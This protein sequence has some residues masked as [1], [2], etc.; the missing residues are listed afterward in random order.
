MPIAGWNSSSAS[1]KPKEALKSMLRVDEGQ[2]FL[3]YDAFRALSGH[4]TPHPCGI[5]DERLHNFGGIERVEC[6]VEEKLAVGNPHPTTSDHGKALYGID[7]NDIHETGHMKHQ[8]VLWWVFQ[9]L[10]LHQR[11]ARKIHLHFVWR[12]GWRRRWAGLVWSTSHAVSWCCP[13]LH[14]WRGDHWGIT[15]EI[16]DTGY[17]SLVIDTMDDNYLCPHAS[18]WTHVVWTVQSQAGTLT[19]SRCAAMIRILWWISP[20]KSWRIDRDWGE[21]CGWSG[22]LLQM[23]ILDQME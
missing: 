1:D 14:S 18:R 3:T 11:P 19:A 13:T 21:W 10:Y 17:P 22:L 20:W 15:T 7:L 16:I 12:P 8:S 2:P 9:L 23:I 6:Y 4:I 5:A